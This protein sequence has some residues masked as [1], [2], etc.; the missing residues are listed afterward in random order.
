[1]LPLLSTNFLH[2][3]PGP[4][5]VSAKSFKYINTVVWEKESGLSISKLCIRQWP[6]PDTTL[7]EDMRPSLL[8]IAVNII[9]NH[10]ENS[11]SLLISEK[12]RFFNLN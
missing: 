1:M 8:I 7:Q 12:M 2:D 3:L 4:M 11:V 6:Q 10:R 5:Q 9:T